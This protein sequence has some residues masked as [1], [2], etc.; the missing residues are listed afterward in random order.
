MPVKKPEQT[1]PLPLIPDSDAAPAADEST[2]QQMDLLRGRSAYKLSD[3][4]D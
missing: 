2:D 1:D 4:P 3:Y